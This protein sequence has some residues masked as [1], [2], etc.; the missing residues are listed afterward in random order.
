MTANGFRFDRCASGLVVVAVLLVASGCA[1]TK[2]IAVDALGSSLAASGSS[3][4][5][6]EDPDLVME[7]APFGL[8]TYESLLA[9]SPR[10][11]GL[12]LAASSGFCA[13]AFLLQQRADLLEPGRE[14]EARRLYARAEQTYLRARDYALRGLAVD[15]PNLP[16]AIGEG[17]PDAL[18]RVRGKDAGFL[19]WAGVSW[20]GAIALARDDA[21]RL[22]ELPIAGALVQ[23]V[24]ALDDSYDRGAAHEFL[25]TYEA[26]RPGGSVAEARA[27]YEKARALQN[28]G[29]ASLFVAYAEA[30]MVK[31]QD[32]KAFL[33]LLDEAQAVDAHAVAE[34]TTVNVL[35]QRRAQWLRAR[36]PDLFLDTETH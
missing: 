2:R 12:L 29:K 28:H 23:R 13:Y 11:R 3:F 14:A 26:S 6:D 10:N 24:V 34:W 35:A 25:V 5:R 15:H 18:E 7:A 27:H 22:A 4:S 16:G 21:G 20:A 8:K 30:A 1:T 19:Y 9:V 31:E 33:V 17:R 36:I 32:L